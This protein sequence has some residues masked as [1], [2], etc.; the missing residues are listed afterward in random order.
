MLVL[1]GRRGARG[2]QIRAGAATRARARCYA[3]R[4]SSLPLRALALATLVG[5]APAPGDELA[6]EPS[7]R[8]P[9]AA[10]PRADPPRAPGDEDEQ[11]TRRDATDA[12]DETAETAPDGP[13]YAVDGPGDIL[14]ARLVENAPL[15]VESPSEYCVDGTLYRGAGYRAADLNLFGKTD[16]IEPGWRGAPVILY[17]HVRRPLLA[18]L[19]EVGP[20]PP[21]Y[22]NIPIP[23]MRS[24]QGSP[25]CGQNIG[26]STR[27]ILGRL[28]YFELTGAR[29]LS[30]VEPVAHDDETLTLRLRNPL[31]VAIEARERGPLRA[32]LR[33]EGTYGKPGAHDRPIALSIPPGASQELTVDR[34]FEGGPLAPRGH[35]IVR[36]AKQ[37]ALWSLALRG[38]I[39][40]ARVE[41]ELPLAGLTVTP[42]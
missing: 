10:A 28:E 31:A 30:I 33:Y 29:S 7:D 38:T 37:H 14:I 1:G 12:T 39:G 36:A 25:E 42:R 35:K 6:R 41:L 20:C 19:T 9:G 32:L 27:E 34:V 8:E 11:V 18:A 24:D 40:A 5:C 13:P 23:Q 17:G 26:R 4:V 21:E 22:D 2:V 16:L 15:R 3:A